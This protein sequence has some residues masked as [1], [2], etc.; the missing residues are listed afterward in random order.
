M[1]LDDVANIAIH[2]LQETKDYVESCGGGSVFIALHDNGEISPVATWDISVQEYFS[3]G[4]KAALQRLYVVAAN[5]KTT[6]GELDEEFK[7][8]RSILESV[9]EK[10]RSEKSK[11]EALNKTLRGIQEARFKQSTSQTSEPEESK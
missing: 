6:P 2:V 3:R 4:F 8:V 9:R 7:S 1:A 5:V 10:Q 11:F